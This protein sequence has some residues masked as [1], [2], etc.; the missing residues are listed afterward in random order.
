M[1]WGLIK[2]IGSFL[3]ELFDYVFSWVEY[4]FYSSVDWVL[5]QLMNF[6]SLIT[7]NFDFQMEISSSAADTFLS[8]VAMLDAIFPL[9]TFFTCCSV[10]FS[11]LVVWTIY[12][13]VKSWIP[14]VSG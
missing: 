13:F 8:Y 14:T 11:F 12:R 4:G 1:I 10:Y 2:L 3:L 9:A 6:L 7:T 5:C